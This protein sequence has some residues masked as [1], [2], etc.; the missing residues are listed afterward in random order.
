MSPTSYQ[1]ADYIEQAIRSVVDQDYP[2]LEYIIVDGGSKDGTVDII[3]KYETRLTR[4]TSEPDNGQYDALNK[5]FAQTSGEIMAWLNSDD[6]YT[7]WAFAVVADIF[8]ALPQIEWLTTLF[9]M[10]WDKEGRAV[11]CRQSHGFTRSG[12]FRGEHLNSPG[13]RNS[14]WIQQES[15]FWRRSLWERAG[16][17]LNAS[18]RLAGDF[19]LWARFYQHT[20]LIGVRAP[21][22]GFRPARRS[23]NRRPDE[24]LH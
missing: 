11:H 13:R 18:L 19:D 7:P 9:P 14:G 23:E 8:A 21:L 16:G 2:D 17:Y 24:G 1:Q 3:R 22:A 20:D 4:W 6:M 12:F 10:Q 5:G 15:T